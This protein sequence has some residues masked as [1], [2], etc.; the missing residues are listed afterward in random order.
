MIT[1]KKEN[2]VF[3][4][5]E[6]LYLSFGESGESYTL[7]TKYEDLSQYVVQVKNHLETV[8]KNDKE[9]NNVESEYERLKE[10]LSNVKLIIMK[11]VPEYFEGGL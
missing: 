5:L 8:D 7:T 4:E 3:E 9:F 1:D 2:E 10:L 6:E 11:H